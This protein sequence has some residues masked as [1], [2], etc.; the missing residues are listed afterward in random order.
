MRLLSPED[1]P[2]LFR[3]PCLTAATKA[4]LQLPESAAAVVRIQMLRCLDRMLPY[5]SGSCAC[6]WP[7]SVVSRLAHLHEFL[8][9]C[10]FK[11]GI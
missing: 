3:K 9:A 11:D 2:A 1:A 4:I 8:N 5:H 7:G 6:D 10:R